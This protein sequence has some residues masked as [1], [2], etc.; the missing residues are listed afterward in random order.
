[1]PIRLEHVSHIYGIKT[2]FEFEALHD[3]CLSI[4]EGSFTAIVGHTG[5]GKSTLIQHLNAL[6]MPTS[7]KVEVGDYT[8][9]PKTKIKNVKHLRK[10]AGIVFQFPEYQLFESNVEKDVMFGPKNFGVSD[11]EAKRQAHEALQLVGISQDYYNKSPFDL[12]GGEKRRVA[13]AGILAM[14]PKILILDEPTAGLDPQGT[15][16]MMQLFEKIHQEGTTIVLVSH[17]M[18]IVMEYADTVIVMEN[19]KIHQITTPTALF[20]DPHFQDFSL[21]LPIVYQ[22]AAAC[23]EHGLA[24]DLSKIKNVETL[25]MEIKKARE[26]K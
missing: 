5:S 14:K 12:S 20:Q 8:I 19:G 17:D 22:F 10:Y 11:E 23:I 6:L 1:M 26:R 16:E 18:D 2:P 3:I 15:R 24:L 4:E 21:D 13:I 9:L 25:A 7:G